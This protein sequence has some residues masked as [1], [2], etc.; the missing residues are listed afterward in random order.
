MVA[1][2]L[3]CGV[4]V[5][6]AIGILIV[7]YSRQIRARRSRWPTC[8]GRIMDAKV[9]AWGGGDYRI[10]SSVRRS[11]TLSYFYTVDQR[12]YQGKTSLYSRERQPHLLERY[13]PGA[14]V[15]VSFNPA[16][17]IVS[18]ISDPN[19]HVQT[20]KLVSNLLILG[21]VALMFGYMS[22]VFS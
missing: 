5:L 11:L 2:K 7:L 21:F 22:G 10:S 3:L 13:K 9:T 14:P 15:D 17:P 18:E 20:A 1:W 16:R 12:G 8:T 6:G 19:M 4:T